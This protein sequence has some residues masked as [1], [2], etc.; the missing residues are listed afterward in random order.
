MATYQEIREIWGNASND[1]LKA[2]VEVATVIS[3]QAF[4]VSATASTDE[5]KWASSVLSNPRGEAQ[6][7]LMSVIAAN[8]SVT[9]AQMQGASDAAVQTQIDS[10]VAGLVS[11]F[12][13]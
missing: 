3:A 4:L 8:K 1:G 6:K 12:G 10:I 13:A 5:L 7:A 2:Q 11:A 9:V